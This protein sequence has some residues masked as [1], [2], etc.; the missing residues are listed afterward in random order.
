M[1]LHPRFDLESEFWGIWRRYRAGFK[2]YVLELLAAFVS[3]EGN[4]FTFTCR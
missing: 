1:V 2:A 3:R 4:N